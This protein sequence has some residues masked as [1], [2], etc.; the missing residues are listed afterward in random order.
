VDANARARLTDFGL[1]VV[2][3]A[4][5]TATASGVTGSAHW[6]ASELLDAEQYKSEVN[7]KDLGRPTKKTDV[8]SLAIT[9]WEVGDSP[10]ANRRH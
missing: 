5:V 1:A 3:Y 6:M 10:L 7:A 2:I 4:T 9:A 8:Y